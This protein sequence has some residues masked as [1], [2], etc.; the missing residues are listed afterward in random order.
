MRP[1]RSCSAPIQFAAGEATTPAAQITVAASMRPPSNDTPC[2]SQPVTLRS[3][4]DLD[5]HALQRA[6]GIV[7]ELLG[8]GRQHPQTGLDQDDAR[9]ARID[10]AKV[11][12]Q[13]ALRHLGDGAGHFHAGGAAADNDKVSNRSPLGVVFH[14]LGAFEGDQE[15]PP[16]L[17]R[18]GDVFQTGRV[19]RPIVVAEIGVGRAGGEDQIIVGSSTSLVRTRRACNIDAG[20]PRHDH[21][22]VFL[23]AQDRADRPCHVRRRQAPRSRPDKAMAESN[24]DCA[25]RSASRRHRSW[26]GFLSLSIRRNPHRQS[27]P[28][29]AAFGLLMLSIR[30]SPTPDILVEQFRRRARACGSWL[31]FDLCPRRFRRISGR[32]GQINPRM[33]ITVTTWNINSVR[34]RID[35]VAK[36][37]KS[38]RPDILCLQE[39]KCPG[40]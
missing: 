38:V 19:R 2:A 10:V 15:A 32:F 7:R 1:A 16:D 39:T 28:A 6:R 29:V 11:V 18:V 37:I 3:E 33:Q 24:G 8:K 13:S 34:F 22:G 36:F 25:R 30:P 9:A 17:G 23:L 5:A 20:N 35:L 26:P 27:R 14:H 4:L 40:R 31:D 21:A 12:P